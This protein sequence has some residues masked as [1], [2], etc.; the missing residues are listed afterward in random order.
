[1]KLVVAIHKVLGIDSSITS[2]HANRPAQDRAGAGASVGEGAAAASEYGAASEHTTVE[3]VSTYFPHPSNLTLATTPNQSHHL[4]GRTSRTIPPS[5]SL[6][7]HP[8][9]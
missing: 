7:F 8:F 1:M 5:N 2:V 4:G 9:C 3:Y 6:V